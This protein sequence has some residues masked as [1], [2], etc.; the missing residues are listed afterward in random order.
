[1]LILA[2]GTSV[3][4]YST[5]IQFQQLHSSNNKMVNG[6]F[7]F[8]PSTSKSPHPTLRKS[9]ENSCVFSYATAS[10]LRYL[11]RQEKSQSPQFPFLISTKENTISVTSLT[12]TSPPSSMEGGLTRDGFCKSFSRSFGTRSSKTR[13]S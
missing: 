5:C 1:M 12:N 2:L 13:C 10:N 7:L 3:K 11:T 4:G 6:Y 9:L 8:V